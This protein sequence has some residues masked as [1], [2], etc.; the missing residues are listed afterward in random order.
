M[1]KIRLTERKAKE[2]PCFLKKKM[3]AKVY[4]LWVLTQRIQ[5][6]AKTDYILA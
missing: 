6:F 2:K 5:Q 3:Q 4:K 1:T